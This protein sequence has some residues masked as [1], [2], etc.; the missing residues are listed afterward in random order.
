MAQRYG[1]EVPVA[2]IRTLRP[3]RPLDLARTLRPV[4]RGGIDPCMRLW[5]DECW[6]ATR[7]PDG[8]ATLHLRRIGGEIHA[9]AW[10]P[11]A[12]W[13]L[14]AAPEL[15]GLHDDDTGFEPGIPL[16]HDLARRFPGL[17]IGRTK[18][19][20]EA[21]APTIIEQKVTGSDARNAWTWLVRRLGEPAPGPLPLLLPPSPATLA[22]TPSWVF[23]RANIERRR[24]DTIVRTMARSRRL[25]ET[26]AMPMADA[27]QRLQAF[28]GIGPWSAAEVA[29]VALGDP[30]AVSV[31][32]YHLKNQVSWALAG[33]ARGTDERM[34]EL[35][36][37]WR[38][39]RAR[40]LRLLGAGGIHAPRRGA[41]MP[42]RSI[43]RL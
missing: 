16:L 29:A 14:E 12:G 22:A 28:P 39:H 23:H 2:A 31:G 6:R 37:P 30:D 26:S 24:A 15:L 38:G 32:D 3:T 9:E 4:R 11:G 41:R 18:A 40:V 36:E 5:A 25:E 34:V 7:T 33:E 27:Y 8:A 43:V 17:R 21:L 20:A 19:V 1:R 10:G 42:N 13:A 35:L